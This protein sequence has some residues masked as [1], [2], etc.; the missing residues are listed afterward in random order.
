VVKIDEELLEKV[1]LLAKVKIEPSAREK[2]MQEMEKLL[3][4]ME[5]LNTS[6]TDEIEPL[7]HGVFEEN[8]FRDDVVVNVDGKDDALFNAPKQVIGQYIVPK[9]V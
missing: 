5:K 8:V 3:A 6:D 9:T 1:E 7:S 2:T 4:Y